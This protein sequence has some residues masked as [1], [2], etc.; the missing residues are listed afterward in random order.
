MIPP[1]KSSE[2]VANMECVL[3]VYKRPYNKKYAVICMDESPKQIIEE[4]HHSIAMRPGQEVRIAYEYVRLGVVDIF[5]ANELLKGKRLA[6]VT[7]FKTKKDWAMFVKR[8]TDEHY[9]NEKKLD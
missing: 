7:E 4:G 8:I 9:P 3:D 6:Q 2:F 1:E 5:M